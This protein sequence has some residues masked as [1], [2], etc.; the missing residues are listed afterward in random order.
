MKKIYL[1]IL[2]GLWLQTHAQNV[3]IGISP[4]T[5]AKL[6]VEGVVGSGATSAI[7]GT[8]SAGISFQRNWPT[9]GFNQYRDDVAPGSQ[10]KFMSSGYA[11]IQYMDPG[12]GIYAFD[13]FPSGGANSFTPAGVRSITVAP[14]G[15]TGIR[16]DYLN[17]SLVVARG[18]GNDGTAVFAGPEQW[19]HFNYS[20]NEDTYIRAG[21]SGGTVY[22]NKIPS[23]SIL[24]GTTSA[25]IGIN[26]GDPFFT[27]EVNQP[28]GQKAFT[29]VDQYN[30][31]WAM[32]AN[33]INTLNNG[34]G[35]ALDFYYNNSGRCR[36][37]FWNGAL[38]VLSDERLKRDIEPMEPVLEKVKKLRPVRYE[39]TRNNPNHFKAIGMI[40]QEVKPLFPLMVRQI[41]DENL[42]GKSVSDAL[43][44]DYT[45]FGVIAIKALQEQQVQLNALEKE[46]MELLD[47]LVKLEKELIV[48]Q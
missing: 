29:L 30:Y 38:V 22:I 20:S 19:S 8:N 27:I 21:K 32:A 12:S 16:T 34:Q 44:M 37:Q 15:N 48:N 11:A 3:G 10:G 31:R 39:M 45:S 24:V 42:N 47:R 2:S 7:F 5:R 13:M 17:A 4:A 36:F 28:N 43:V 33:H 9:I 1:I 14:N 35:V 41:K 26:S 25:H 18:Q 23:G 6:E 40:A 46:K